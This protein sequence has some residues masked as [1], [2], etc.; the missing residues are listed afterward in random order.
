MFPMRCK[1][2]V[3]LGLALL[4]TFVMAQVGCGD[5]GADE[6]KGVGGHCVTDDGCFQVAKPAD[7]DLSF[8]CSIASGKL[9]SGDCN[10]DDYER[11][12]TQVTSVS[13]G[14]G[15]EQEVTYVNFFP[16]GSD[17]SCAGDEEEL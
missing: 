1:S 6:K 12:C 10:A 15:P 17:I 2:S 3:S 7:Y 9:G 5:D 14:D 4:S 13:S 16:E 11:K 8:D